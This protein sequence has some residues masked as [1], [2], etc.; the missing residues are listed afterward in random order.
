MKFEVKNRWTGA[1]QFTADIECD[2]DASVS[3]KLGLAV[4]WAVKA[5]AY[6]ADAYLAGANLTGANLTDANLT[7]ANLTDAN[8]TDAY[9]ARANLTDANLAD[10]NLARAYLAGANLTDANLTGAN[11]TDANLTDAYLA[12]AYLAGANLAR[13]NLADALK[14]DEKDIPIISGIDAA[15]LKEIEAGG[16][17]DMSSWHGPSNHWCGTTHCRAGWAIHIAGTPGKKLQ[18]RFGPHIAGVL[19]YQA[20]RPGKRTPH[21]FAST[22]DALADIRACAGDK[23]QDAP[24]FPGF[25]DNH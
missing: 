4:K 24:D 12:D 20:S 16:K 1:V 5:D 14:V 17:L 8:L 7:G 6:L 21:F 19:I 9:L 18:D 11:L 22:E 23:V 2:A 10:A 3:V 13:A 25:S 15:I